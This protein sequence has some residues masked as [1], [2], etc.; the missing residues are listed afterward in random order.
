MKAN[1]DHSAIIE[2]LGGSTK[3]ARALGFDPS[4]GTQRVNNWKRRG[5]PARVLL[6]HKKF[7]DKAKRAA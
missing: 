5:I 2:A 6:N 1:I 3:V 4:I 7:F